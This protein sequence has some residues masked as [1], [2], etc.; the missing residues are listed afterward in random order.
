MD[1]SEHGKSPLKAA[2]LQIQERDGA[3]DRLTFM[4]TRMNAQMLGGRER[5]AK[6]KPS[7]P[8]EKP[9]SELTRKLK[10][11]DKRDKAYAFDV[12]FF[13]ISFRSFCFTFSP[14][15]CPV[16]ACL[17]SMTLWP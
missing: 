16:R 10:E 1:R 9:E 6:D 4:A 12:F 14:F 2:R 15:S 8:Q 7:K 11:K 3:A 17:C 13:L 5:E